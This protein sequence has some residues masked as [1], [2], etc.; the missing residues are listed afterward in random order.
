MSLEGPL[1][2][3][4]GPGQSARAGLVFLCADPQSCR[5][6]SSRTAPWPSAAIRAQEQQVHQSAGQPGAA[7]AKAWRQKCW[8]G[9]SA[10][11]A[12]GWTHLSGRRLSSG[13]SSCW[14]R[15]SRPSGPPAANLRPTA[16]SRDQP[17]GSKA[18]RRGSGCSRAK[19]SQRTDRPGNAITATEYKFLLLF[20]VARLYSSC[21]S[22]VFNRNG[23][24]GTGASIIAPRESVPL[25]NAI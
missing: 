6:Q 7:Q 24:N 13:L 21:G 19:M 16:A 15:P 11:D 3:S 20:I 12:V 23:Q 2:A 18:Q 1:T 5:T 14:S 8:L 9:G 22:F 17:S 10:T 25:R 4:S